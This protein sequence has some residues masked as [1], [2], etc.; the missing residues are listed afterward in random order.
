[1]LFALFCFVLSHI[2]SE[3]SLILDRLDA[4]I[5]RLADLA[6]DPTINYQALVIASSWLQTGLEVYLL[7]V[8]LELPPSCR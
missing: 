2:L 4:V 3:M 6:D 5:S 7:Y 8:K 1:M